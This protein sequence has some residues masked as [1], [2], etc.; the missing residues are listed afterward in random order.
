MWRFAPCCLIWMLPAF[1]QPEAALRGPVHGW[2]SQAPLL[3]AEDVSM[4][5]ATPEG[6]IHRLPGL[7]VEELPLFR[8]FPDSEEPTTVL[9]RIANESA[10][11]RLHFEDFHLPKG[12]RL[13]VYGIDAQQQVVSA[14]GPYLLSGPLSSGEFWTKAVS[15]ATIVIELQTGELQDGDAE[16]TLPFR[17]DEV[18][19]SDV[20]EKKFQSE[21]QPGGEL[22]ASELRTSWFR[23]RV[24][25]HHVIDGMAVWEGDILL[26]RAEELEPYDGEP[27]DGGKRQRQ[28]GAVPG[29]SY[30]WPGG[31]VP[32]TIDPTLPNQDRIRAAISHWNTNLEGYVKLAPRTTEAYYL[33]FVPA[34]PS[35][36][37]SYLGMV[38]MAG[39]PVNIGEYCSTGNII[40]EIGHAIGLYHEHTRSDRDAYVRILEQNM[41][42]GVAFNFE[43]QPTANF[44]TYDYHSIMHYSAY[45]FSAN[46]RATIET[47]PAGI[48]IGQRNGLSTGDIAGVKSM[49]RGTASAAPPATPAVSAV[50]V[51]FTASPYGRAVQVD[52]VTTPTPAVFQWLPGSTHT[53]SAPNVT[54]DGTRYEFR[55]WSDGGAQTHTITTPASPTTY[56]ATYNVLHRLTLNASP[57]GRVSSYPSPADGF[58]PA[59]SAIAITAT[60]NPNYCFTSWTGVMPVAS[61]AIAVALTRPASITANFQPGAVSTPTPIYAPVEGG[62]VSAAIQATSG[63]LWRATSFSNWIQV[64]NPAGTTSAVLRLRVERNPNPAVRRTGQLL[65]NSELVTVLQ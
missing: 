57:G 56:A 33:T 59:N 38:R 16:A 27:F 14:Y 42:A 61:S 19:V 4:G 18:A 60:P 10:A 25:R 46:G 17:V 35:T 48:P 50:S 12:A 5:R 58:H 47:I 26:G 52:G 63:C 37:S 36:C 7:K 45:A 30:R 20:I 41:S 8:N 44:G 51:T 64:E 9:L 1:A 65:V 54:E 6:R 55:L 32:Y 22:R 39:Q 3:V 24:V 31:V 21:I 62:A 2:I 49:Y 43:K 28:A 53:V 34:S 15:G 23:G 29:D 11:M 13:Y 40:H